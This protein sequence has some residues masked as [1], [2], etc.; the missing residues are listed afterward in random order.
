VD[1]ELLRQCA[2]A[3]P[4]TRVDVAVSGG[5]DSVG[6]LLLALDAGLVVHVHHVD[7]HARATSGE[8]AAFVA[9]LCAELDVA[10]VLHNVDVPAGPNFESR[11]RQARRSALPSGVLT[12]HTMDDAAETILMNLLRG[13]GRQGLTS[14]SD[15]TTKP[16]L[17]VRRRDLHDYVA[18]RGIVAR[19]DESN[20]DPRYTRNRVRH[21]LLPLMNDVMQRDVVPVLMRATGV[22]DDELAWLHQITAPDLL[23]G[24]GDAD[25]RELATWPAARLRHWLRGVLESANDHGDVYAPSV[26]E[27]E[28][29]MAVVRGEVVACELSG[30][31]RLSRQHQRLTLSE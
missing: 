11:A 23:L 5:P 6:L 10:F 15:T 29:A 28:R 3:S 1:S 16:L 14:M 31:R 12:G 21:E 9:Q 25:C 8:D 18:Q 19:L 17:G 30:G 4:G 7:H 27:V 20:L 2:F 22:M 26:D 24:L 13:A